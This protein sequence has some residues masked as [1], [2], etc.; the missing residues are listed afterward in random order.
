MFAKENEGIDSIGIDF[1]NYYFFFWKA[2][3]YI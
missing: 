3:K 1:V 2:F